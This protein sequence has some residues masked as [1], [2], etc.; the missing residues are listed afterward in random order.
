M[1]LNLLQWGK[2]RLGSRWFLWWQSFL[3]WAGGWMVVSF[4][5][6]GNSG[7]RGQFWTW[8]YRDAY[9]T[10]NWK[11][12]VRKRNEVN[13]KM[14]DEVLK[15]G[16]V[17]QE[18]FVCWQSH[19]SCSKRR[20]S[21]GRWWIGNRWGSSMVPTD[22]LDMEWGMGEDAGCTRSHGERDSPLEAVSVTCGLC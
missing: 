21:K 16:E 19:L 20:E 18:G 12:W 9:K 4:P 6:L 22:F 17:T 15:E 5:E 7:S 1:G 8:C 13:T 3:A 10:P 14:V 2:K 11:L